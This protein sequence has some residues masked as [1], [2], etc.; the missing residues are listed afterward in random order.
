MIAT[1]QEVYDF[2]DMAMQQ[3]RLRGLNDIEKQLDDALH[4]GSSGM[5][6]LGAI[7]AVFIAQ[8]KQLEKVL[9]REKIDE[10]VVFVNK[11]FGME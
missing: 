3:C 7:K 11:A 8:G 4:L 6:I 5:E 1:A 10:I 2:V 9:D